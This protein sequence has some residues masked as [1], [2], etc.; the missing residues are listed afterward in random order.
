MTG[1]A[2]VGAGVASPMLGSPADLLRPPAGR[3]AGFDPAALLGGR[4]L[5]YKDRATRLGLLAAARAL[6]DAGLLDPATTAGPL[7]PPAGTGV[8]V[9][10]NLGNLDTVCRT[11]GAIAA[12]TVAGASPIDLPNASSN[13]IASSIAIRFGLR[14]PNV[15]VCNGASSGLDAA[16]LAASLIGAG[17]VRAVVLVGVEPVNEVVENLARTPARELFDGAAAVVLEPEASARARGA[18]PRARLGHYA[19]RASAA[20]SAGRALGHGGPPGLWLAGRTTAAPPALV[21]VHREDLEA[22]LGAASGALG[23]LQVVAGACW[24]G[25]ERDGP[26]LATAGAA[27]DGV[28]SLLLT[29][30]GG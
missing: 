30:L 18:V 23:V 17:R 20:G 8:V 4:G 11:A 15:M 10:S 1:V 29:S 16:F 5:R 6:E 28:S 14:G 19:R 22:R 25:D 12:G 24:L 21:H 7:V 9:S 26:V 13:V 2:V 27:A 3:V